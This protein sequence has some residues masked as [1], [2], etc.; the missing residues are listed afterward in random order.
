MKF[1]ADDLLN[2]HFERRFR[3]YDVEQVHEFLEAIAREWESTQRELITLQDEV[4]RQNASIDTFQARERSLLDALETAK[5]VADELKRK[6]QLEREQIL[7]DAQ[8]R[9]EQIIRQAES[10]REQIYTETQTLSEHREVLERELRQ[11]LGAHLM[12]LDNPPV[13]SHKTDPYPVDESR[14]RRRPQSS[15]TTM[16]ITEEDITSSVDQIDNADSCTL[17]GM[18]QDT[19]TMP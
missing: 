16:K 14:M 9:A 15:H 8:D 1:N 12:V 13:R 3:G 19:P 7:E 4:S 5:T 2:Q 18:G 6:A 11:V 17:L 10:Q